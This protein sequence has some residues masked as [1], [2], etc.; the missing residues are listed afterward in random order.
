MTAAT[1][2]GV[3]AHPDDEAYLSAGLMARARRRGDRVVVVTAT[4]GEHGT[5]DADRWPP[6]RLAARRRR[7]LRAAL[8][9]VDVTEHHVLGYPDGACRDHDGSARVAKVIARIRPDTIVTFG[10]DGMTGHPDH[11]AVSDWTTSAWHTSGRRARLWYAT[12]TPAFHERWSDLNDHV[13][14]WS[15]TDAPPCTEPHALARF[16]ELDDAALDGKLAALRAHATQT[17]P[18][19]DLV[20]EGTF[21]AWWST[22]AFVDARTQP[23]HHRAPVGAAR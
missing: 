10:P 14:M 3:W 13:G 7:E 19:I 20:G 9:A 17:G 6:R 21:R 1:L 22:E 4:A 8:A 2:L 16:L 15:Y 12:L 18:L 23:A 5:D 11:R